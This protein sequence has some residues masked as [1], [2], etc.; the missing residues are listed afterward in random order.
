[1][2][3]KFKEKSFAAGCDRDRI[4][5]IERLMPLERLYEVGIESLK[6]VKEELGLS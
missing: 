2:K 1:M 5:M 3:K 6:D 4:R